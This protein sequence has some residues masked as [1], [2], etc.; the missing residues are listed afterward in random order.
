VKVQSRKSVSSYATMAVFATVLLVGSGI[1]ASEYSV[2]SRLR[3]DNAGSSTGAGVGQ[4][5]YEWTNL[6]SREVQAPS[7][8]WAPQAAYSPP[9]NEVVLFGGYNGSG[10]ANGDTWAF[11]SYRWTELSP[12]VSPPARWN[13]QMIYDASDGY[14]VLFGGRN[15]T[16][17]FND[18]WSYGA[19]GWTQIHT[20][21]APSPRGWFGMAYDAAAGVVVLFGGSIGN[22]PAGSGSPSTYY[23]DTWTYHAGVWTNVTRTAGQPPSA[24]A[25]EG[26]AY[27]PVI[28]GVILQGGGIG[29]S[30]CL[31]LYNDTWEFTGTEWVR[32]SPSAAPPA[33][34]FGGLLFDT[35]T[36]STLLYQGGSNQPSCSTF[37]SQVWMF[38]G[39]DWSLTVPSSASSPPGRLGPAWVDDPADDLELLFGGSGASAYLGDTWILTYVSTLAFASG[40][41]ASRYSADVGQTTNFQAPITSGGLPPYTYLWQGLPS[42]CSGTTTP[43][44][45]C[46]FTGPSQSTIFAS[47][48][49]FLGATIVSASLSFLV[50][51]DPAFSS[52]PTADPDPVSVGS[53]VIFTAAV[54]GGSGGFSFE[55]QGLPP[56]CASANASSI[57]CTPTVNGTY[58]IS[59]SV[60]DSNG[61]KAA[62]PV[63]SEVV[64]QAVTPRG[65]VPGI[66]PFLSSPW[67]LAAVS[68]V[69]FAAILGIWLVKRKAPS[70]SDSKPR[71]PP[72]AAPP[73]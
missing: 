62:S 57:A 8:R 67:F 28:G 70:M 6:T 34:I 73:P 50:F 14:L 46:S 18:T 22:L 13:G 42:G 15:D 32:L 9:L 3:G 52:Y 5:S 59:V 36:G 69:A 17:E 4:E 64:L 10:F 71:P 65:P 56:G 11:S 53:S 54:S 40:I 1:V 39:G 45:S 38:A 16:Q 37:A 60:I 63:G 51:P 29:Y 55:W 58:A 33:S 61:E 31:T 72:P 68:V 19:A 24:R 26:M 7:P 43:T 41:T 35:D 44:P 30:P 23:N 2:L 21:A 20:S 25:P 66:G 27:D 47:V 49:D 48:T 12:A